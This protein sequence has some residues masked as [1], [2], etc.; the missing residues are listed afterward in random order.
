MNKAK[1]MKR[2]NEIYV[3]RKVASGWVDVYTAPEQMPKIESD[4][5]IA[6]VEAVC[7][8][9]AAEQPVERVENMYLPTRKE[10]FVA[11]ALTGLLADGNI[12]LDCATVTAVLAA[13]AVIRELDGED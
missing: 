11:A 3:E 1:I 4:Q 2:A 12:S 5:V 13:H 9:G 8:L 10:Y 7:E 6:V